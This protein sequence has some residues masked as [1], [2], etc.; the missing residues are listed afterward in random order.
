MIKLVA[1]R[2]LPGALAGTLLWSALSP[3]RPALEGFAKAAGALA[4]ERDVGG[5]DFPSVQ[6]GAAAPSAHAHRARELR[7]IAKN[8]ESRGAM[9]DAEALGW[10]AGDRAARPLGPKSA[11]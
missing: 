10:E 4:G 8:V 1:A 3:L 11:R 9:P 5:V 6:P 2:L 7:D